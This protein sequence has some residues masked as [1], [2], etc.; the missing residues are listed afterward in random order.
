MKT[1]TERITLLCS[2]GFKAFLAK[3]SLKE[4]ISVSELVCRR[5]ART[6]IEDE[7]VLLALAQ[8]LRK[9]TAEAR[10]ALNEGLAAARHVLGKSAQSLL[11]RRVR[12]SVQDAMPLRNGRRRGN[13]TSQSK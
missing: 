5:C 6:P 9:S 11:R 1:K 3:E 10:R 2:G 7:R 12:N 8:E 4:G 13:S